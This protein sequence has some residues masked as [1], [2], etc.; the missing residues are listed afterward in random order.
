MTQQDAATEEEW[1]NTRQPRVNTACTLPHGPLQAICYSPLQ[2]SEQ[3]RMEWYNQ[4]RSYHV[5]VLHPTVPALR[6]ANAPWHVMPVKMYRFC[7]AKQLNLQK[8]RNSK[9][10]FFA[11]TSYLPGIKSLMNDKI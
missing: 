2:P 8:R 3:H 7:H 11:P 6:P 5:P 9:D 1:S 10:S 4:L